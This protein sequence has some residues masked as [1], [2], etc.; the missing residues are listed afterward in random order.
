MY[1]ILFLEVYF[2]VEEKISSA[3]EEVCNRQKL[4]TLSIS[5]Y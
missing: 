5:G 4:I 2:D 3:K 1:F